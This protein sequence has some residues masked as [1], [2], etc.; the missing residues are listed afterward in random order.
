MSQLAIG[1][2]TTEEGQMDK[3]SDRKE[4]TYCIIC[5]SCVY[6][7]EHG[8]PIVVRP[9]N[10]NLLTCL[11]IGCSLVTIHS[12]MNGEFSTNFESIRKGLVDV[13]VPEESAMSIA[14]IISTHGVAAA[15]A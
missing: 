12:G 7:D 5:G 3:F 6:W 4:I 8:D 1:L 13:G 15:A 14:A 2:E 10:Q 9:G 11:Q